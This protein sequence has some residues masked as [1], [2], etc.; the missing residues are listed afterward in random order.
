MSSERHESP[1]GWVRRVLS[2]QGSTGTWVCGSALVALVVVGFPAFGLWIRA[3]AAAGSR[4]A[5]DD[6]HDVAHAAELYAIVNPAGPCPDAETLRREGFVS[7]DRPLVDP[8]GAPFEIECAADVITVRSRGPDRA[9]GTSDD[10][11]H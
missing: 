3:R 1:P 7:S 2:P 6:A 5:A 10:I 4:H 11:V 8:R 9:A